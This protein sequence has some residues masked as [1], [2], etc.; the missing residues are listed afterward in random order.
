[1][2]RGQCYDGA[3]NMKKAS[4]EIKAIEPKALYLHCYSHSLNLAVSDTIKQVQ[5]MSDALDHSLE[6]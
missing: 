2:C 3:A 4:Q 5:P 6:I 1:M